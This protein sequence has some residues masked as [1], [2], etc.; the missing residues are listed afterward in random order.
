MKALVYMG[1]EKVEIQDVPVPEPQAG[2]ALLRIHASGICGSDIHGFLGHSER[3]KPPLVLG[4]E[5]VAAIE[6][7]HPSARSDLKPGERVCINPLISCGCCGA[8]QAGRQNL[9]AEWRLLGMD[10]V[11]G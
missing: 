7:V 8:C 3:R 2:E 10:R 11:S 6:R 4:H 9:C 5:G 1:P